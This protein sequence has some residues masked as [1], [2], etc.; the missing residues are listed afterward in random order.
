MNISRMMKSHELFQSLSFE[1]IEQVS[2]FSASRSFGK[3]E[4]VF[5]RQEYGSHFFVIVEGRVNLRLPSP[6]GESSLVVARLQQ[7]DIFGLSPLL[8]FE[9]F[10]T[11]AQCAEPSTILAVEVKGFRELLEHNSP[12][13]L[14]VMNM[15]AKAYFSRYTGALERI[16][17]ILDDLAAAV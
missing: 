16:Q 11:N 7:G 8:G 17:R 6:D 9:R 15:V 5:R 4:I 14:S 13:G 12:V 1:E 10:T 2:S 3:D